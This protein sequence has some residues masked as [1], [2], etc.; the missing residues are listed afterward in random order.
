[1][2]FGAEGCFARGEKNIMLQLKFPNPKQRAQGTAS[3]LWQAQ[4]SFR[5][6]QKAPLCLLL[7]SQMWPD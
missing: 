5:P 3:W 7:Q 6:L 1:M 2:L 4:K